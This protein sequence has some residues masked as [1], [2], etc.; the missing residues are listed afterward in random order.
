MNTH[1]THEIRMIR[2]CEEDVL[3]I[4]EELTTV[5]FLAAAESTS[6][7]FDA[8]HGLGVPLRSKIP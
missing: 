3:G 2:A 7:N 1:S 4:L 8:S 5:Q 6:C